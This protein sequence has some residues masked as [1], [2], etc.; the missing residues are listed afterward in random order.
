MKLIDTHAHIFDDQFD[1][2][3]S[4]VILRA[5]KEGVEHFLLPAIDSTTHKQMFDV[6]DQHSNCLPMMGL[7]P[8]SVNDNPNWGKELTIVEEYLKNPPVD[9]FYAV[10]EV[11]LD[12]YWSKEWQKEQTEA[13]DIQLQWSLEYNLPVV[14]HTRSAWVEIIEHLE[15]YKNSGLRGVMHAFGDTM[16]SYYQIKECGDFMFGVGGVVTYKK[17]GLAEVVAQIPLSDIVLETDSPYLTPAPFRGKRNEPA[18]LNYICQK[19]GEVKGVSPETVAEQ[20]TL[21]AINLFKI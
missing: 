10:G 17:S 20:T 12:L 19:I 3:L 14:I 13:F 9:K 8:T 1:E 5:Q 6:C 18:Y 16:E 2:D 15:R 11:G 21:N 7:H 4:E